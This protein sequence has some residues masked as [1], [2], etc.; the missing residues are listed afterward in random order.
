MREVAPAT[1]ELLGL[2]QGTEAK[3]TA[4]TT[5]PTTEAL[6]GLGKEA[7]GKR[8]L[9][10]G[11]MANSRKVDDAVGEGSRKEYSTSCGK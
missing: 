11:M 5:P 2:R 9:L 4:P 3:A 8:A 7:L 1:A 10:A 6:R